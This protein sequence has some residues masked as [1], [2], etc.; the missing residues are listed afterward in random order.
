MPKPE[1]AA[2]PSARTGAAP[3]A[4]EQDSSAPRS[5]EQTAVLAGSLERVDSFLTQLKGALVELAQRPM[6]PA[7]DVAPVVAAVQA[8]FDQSARLAAATSSALVGL[9]AQVQGLGASVEQCVGRVAA[10][11]L[12]QPATADGERRPPEYLIAQSSRLPV[13]L[14]ALAALVIAW[15]ILFWVKTGSPRL[16]IG[17]LVGANLVGCCLLAGGRSR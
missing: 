6:A 14:L 2:E 10:S 17:T 9:G 7:V 11:V 3:S 13:V 12:A 4:G 15:S 8:G 16:A 1:P 5:E